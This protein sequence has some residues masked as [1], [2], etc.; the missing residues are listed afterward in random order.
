MTAE[1]PRE[2]IRPA[3]AALLERVDTLLRDA[4]NGDRDV[5]L[6]E[7]EDVYTIGCAEILELEAEVIRL[8]RRSRSALEAAGNGGAA[9]S[10]LAD[11]AESSRSVERALKQLQSELRHVRTAIEWLQER[12]D[13]TPVGDHARRFDSA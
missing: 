2:G 12:H 8:R 6:S 13:A 5:S 9:Q 4:R 3:P 1:P 10:G 11:L 7:L